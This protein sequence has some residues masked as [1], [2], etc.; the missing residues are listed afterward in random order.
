M[1]ALKGFGFQNH[2]NEKMVF[3]NFFDYL[4]FR[5][6]GFSTLLKVPRGKS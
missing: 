5:H 3:Q 1:R 4:H 6:Q 2:I